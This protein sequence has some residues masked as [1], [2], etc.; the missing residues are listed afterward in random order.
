[1]PSPRRSNTIGAGVV[2]V[3][4]MVVGTAVVA[5]VPASVVSTSPVG[6]VEEPVLIDVLL[7]LHA[8]IRSVMPAHAV[9]ERN[10]MRES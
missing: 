3:G 6:D 8:A 1:M 2:V 10:P 7:L 9:S 4:A 5:D